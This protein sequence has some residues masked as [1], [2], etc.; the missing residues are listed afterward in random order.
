MNFDLQEPIQFN[1]LKKWFSKNEL[2]KQLKVTGRNYCNVQ[3]II[4]TNIEIFER[5][6]GNDIRITDKE[7]EAH[8]VLTTLHNDLKQ[9]K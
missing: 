5:E 7:K 8:D 4:E 9:T 1:S 6:Q 2:P 3:L